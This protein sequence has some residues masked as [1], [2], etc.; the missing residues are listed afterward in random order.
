[1]GTLEPLLGAPIR[2]DELLLG[3]ALAVLLPSIAISYAVYAVFLALVTL[4]AHPGVAAAL[5]RGSDVLAQVLF[6][7][8]IAGWSIWAAVAISTRA[9]EV[10]VAQALATLVSLP[11]IAVPTLIAVDVIHATIGLALVLAAVLLAANV[12]G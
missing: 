6:T 9:G 3:K 2:R 10:R 7:P 5:I 11:S 8:L 1:Q 4:L 12:L